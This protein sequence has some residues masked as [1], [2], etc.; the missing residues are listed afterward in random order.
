[1]NVVSLTGNPRPVEVA[2]AVSDARLSVDLQKNQ[3][4][5]SGAPLMK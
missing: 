3:L 4:P 5:G 1:V 2:R